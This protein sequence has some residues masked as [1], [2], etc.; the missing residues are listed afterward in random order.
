MMTR[1]GVF[2]FLRAFP[3]KRLKSESPMRE[4]TFFRF[5]KETQCRFV[6]PY[7]GCLYHGIRKE[8]NEPDTGNFPKKGR[9]G[10]DRSPQNGRKDVAE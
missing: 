2:H 8:V 4:G 9:P 5:E 7:D 10:R 1:I 3:E 6:N